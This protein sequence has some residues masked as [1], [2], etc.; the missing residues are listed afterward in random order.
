MKRYGVWTDGISKRILYAESA[1]EAVEKFCGLF[2]SEFKYSQVRW[3][4][5][6]AVETEKGMRFQSRVKLDLVDDF[7]MSPMKRVS[8][9]ARI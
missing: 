5:T 3:P 8:A 2:G 9:A 6:V 4:I 1:T 7:I